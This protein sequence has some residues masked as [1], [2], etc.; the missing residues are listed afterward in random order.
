[1]PT[2]NEMP[3]TLDEIPVEKIFK[4][5]NTQFTYRIEHNETKDFYSLYVLDDEN[6]ILYSSKLVFDNDALHAGAA[7]LNLISEIKPLNR[8]DSDAQQLN[9]STFFSQ[10]G[11][12]A[13]TPD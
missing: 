6:V 7:I 11:I 8:V 13:V 10:M 9:L 3:Y 2:F 4:I 5:D 12:V 1:M